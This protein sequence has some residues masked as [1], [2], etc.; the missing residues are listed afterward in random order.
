[1]FRLKTKML[2][3]RDSSN[4]LILVIS[5]RKIHPSVDDLFSYTIVDG[6]PWTA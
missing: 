2:S 5:G 1:M 4:W 6:K 3:M